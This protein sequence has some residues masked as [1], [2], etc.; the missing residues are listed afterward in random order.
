MGPG[1]RA[2]ALAF[3]DMVGA[4]ILPPRPLAQC[5]QRPVDRP[6]QTEAAR[7]SRRCEVA[8]RGPWSCLWHVSL[9]LGRL[10]WDAWSPLW[11]LGG[12]AFA[13]QQEL[14]RATHSCP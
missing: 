1:L 11:G 5:L 3:Q 13:L 7:A 12:K 6:E 14:S 4:K 2:L 10:Q 8:G 9:A